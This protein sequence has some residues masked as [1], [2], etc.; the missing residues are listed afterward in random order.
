MR[1][2]GGQRALA[3]IYN[4]LGLLY[5]HLAEPER[6]EDVFRD[7]IKVYV[8]LGDHQARLNTQHGVVLALLQQKR[9]VEAAELC[10]RSLV[11]IESLQS[12]P[13]EYA[14][15]R[16]WYTASLQKARQGAA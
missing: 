9:F 5:L 7:G 8:D 3:W 11:E 13:E 2:L 14:E 16:G 12:F 6:A 1:P 15:K 4:N 10:E